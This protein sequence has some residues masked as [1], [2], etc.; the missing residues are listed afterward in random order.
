MNIHG[1]HRFAAPRD[2]VFE[3]IRDPRVLMAV[4][5]GC[6]SVAQAGPDE[7]I[8]RITLRLPGAVG[9]YRTTVRLVDVVAPERAG[10]DALVEGAMGSITGRA[11]FTL[12]EA[13]D[14]MGGTA[15][16]YRGSGTIDGPLARLDTRFAERLAESLIAQGLRALDLRLATE[17]SE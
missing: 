2:R 12:A 16:D 17:G 7:Y 4:I 5:P 15:M 10:L 13:D 8:G 3:A 6:E 11:D 1:T 14:G 9:S